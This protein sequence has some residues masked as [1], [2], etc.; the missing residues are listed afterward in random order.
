[1]HVDL[2]ALWPWRY[3]VELGGLMISLLL[4]ALGAKLMHRVGTRVLRRVVRGRPILL[5]V[6]ERDQRPSLWLLESVALQL[7]L[8]STADTLAGIDVAR[9]IVRLF[10][11]GSATWLALEACVAVGAAI[12]VL[13]PAD[14]ADNLGARRIHTQAQVLVR[15]LNVAI[16]LLGLAS[17]LLTFPGVRQ[18]GAS[19]MA[20]AGI[21]G[22]VAGIAARPVLGNLIAG[23]QIALTQ[24]I[25]L[26]DVLV[27]LGDW[28]R[29][30][31]ITGAYVVV[32]IWDDR[33]LVVPL[34]W[35]VENPFENWTRRSA[36]LTGSIFLWVDYSVPIAPLRAELKRLCDQA[37]ECDHR[38]CVLQVTDAN[39]R[40][41]QL[42]ALVS[43][44]DSGK[45]WD[46]CC[47]VREGLIYFIQEK[48]PDSLPRVRVQ[49]QAE[50]LGSTQA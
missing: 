38:V 2:S 5:A 49:W 13:N 48:Y 32:R 17:A 37:P 35:F 30:E 29:V 33:R 3:R 12:L 27:I 43:A 39:D 40:A 20:S 1:M 9:H 23:L 6:L 47:R 31:E 22:L 25:R 15:C 45:S 11:I 19:I 44:S 16:V 18:I 4:A 8:S 46:L 24:P 42:R 50:N 7:V 10:V 21:M 14:V 28:G 36:H 41:I 34:Q 26:D